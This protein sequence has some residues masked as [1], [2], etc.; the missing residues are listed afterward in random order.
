MSEKR[1]L[2][3]FEKLETRY[4]RLRWAQW[5]L[6]ISSILSAIVPA[7]TVALR[8]ALTIKDSG[9]QISLAGF[10]VVILAIGALL[11][12]WGLIAKY[13][14]K[15]PWALL[16]TVGAW[17]MTLL[18]WSLQKIIEDALFIS[19]AL[20][21]GCTAALIMSSVSDF[22]KVQADGIEEEYRKGR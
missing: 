6:F 14:D 20:A 13:K 1:E 15:L 12:T 7:V 18:L 17:I 5:I 8:V 11:M 21:I 9:R 4:K 22:C 3:E 19:L 2:T 10:A 16:A